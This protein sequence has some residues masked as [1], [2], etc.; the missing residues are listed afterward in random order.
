[1]NPQG[2]TVAPEKFSSQGIFLG[3]NWDWEQGPVPIQSRCERCCHLTA[4]LLHLPMLQLHHTRWPGSTRTPYHRG[5]RKCPHASGLQSH[6]SNAALFVWARRSHGWPVRSSSGPGPIWTLP[7]PLEGM[8]ASSWPHSHQQEFWLLFFTFLSTTC[9]HISKE[10]ST[11]Q[12]WHHLPK[13]YQF[14]LSSAISSMFIVL[15][16][17]GRASYQTKLGLCYCFKAGKVRQVVSAA[18]IPI[19]GASLNQEDKLARNTTLLLS[20]VL[21]NSQGLP[22]VWLLFNEIFTAKINIEAKP[23]RTYNFRTWVALCKLTYPQF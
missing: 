3:A 8:Q 4:L 12:W 7:S 17:L 20:A 2:V 6:D 10:N 22:W 9:T 19:L 1:M 15:L 5:S 18:Q 11:E 16:M 21:S 14:L 13:G 23:N